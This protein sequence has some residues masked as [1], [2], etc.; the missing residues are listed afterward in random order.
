LGTLLY[1]LVGLLLGALINL[2]ADDLPERRRPRRPRCAACERV[3]RPLWWFGLVRKLGRRCPECHAP[4]RWRPLLVEVGMA[5]ILGLLWGRYQHLSGELLVVSIYFAAFVLILVTD[6]EHRLILHVV[7]VPAIA[8]A[9]AASFLTVSPLAALLGA[10]VGFTLFYAS[11][12]IGR[13]AFGAGA[14]GFGDVTLATFIG[15]AVGFPLVVVALLTG[16]LAGGMI[17]LLL[18]L[19]RIRRLQSKVPYGPFLL[20][21]AAVTLL[22]G[23]QIVAWYLG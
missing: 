21:G 6:M 19:T 9:L 17:T 2:L 14:M 4:E 10:A 13:L 15:T 20:I 3:Y 12:L 18:L 16:I 11:Y 1:P 8:F 5:L 22:W 23:D 7:T